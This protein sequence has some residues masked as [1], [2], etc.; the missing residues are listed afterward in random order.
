LNSWPGLG[1]ITIKIGQFILPRMYVPKTSV[2]F[3]YDTDENGY[4]IWAEVSWSGCQTIEVATTEQM[5]LVPRNAQ[6]GST[7]SESA[8]P[9][10]LDI[11]AAMATKGVVPAGAVWDEKEGKYK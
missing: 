10:A 11:A 8:S 2:E 9:Y 7:Y 3:S 1:L 6:T 4:P 5:P